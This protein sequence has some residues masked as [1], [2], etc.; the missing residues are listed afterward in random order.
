M[1]QYND[2]QRERIQEQADQLTKNFFSANALLD[3]IHVV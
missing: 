1:D 3:T 2:E